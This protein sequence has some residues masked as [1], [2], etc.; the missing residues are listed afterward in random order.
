MREYLDP[1]YYLRL[2]RPQKQRTP[3]HTYKSLENINTLVARAIPLEDGEVDDGRPVDIRL[4][5]AAAVVGEGY[6]PTYTP[7]RKAVEQRK[8]HKK[9]RLTQEEF[10]GFVNL[11][12][13]NLAEDKFARSGNAITICT[14]ARNGKERIGNLAV[15]GRIV[16]GN[17]ETSELAHPVVNNEPKNVLDLVPDG[18]TICELGRITVVEEYRGIR[19][20]GTNQTT[21]LVEFFIDGP[22]GVVETAQQLG[23]DTM[24]TI[25]KDQFVKHTKSTS[26]QLGEPME[27]SLLPKGLAVA[28]T[29]EGYWKD[30]DDPPCLYIAPIPAPKAS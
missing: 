3:A 26:L 7:Y 12:A 9:R 14:F 30:M 28:E 2:R 21:E 20:D 25:A 11:V 27:L 1:Q 10:G 15:T 24:V 23:C 16:S 22:Q 5:L 19:E 17:L 18:A 29:Y 6:V 13:E 4:N 8:K